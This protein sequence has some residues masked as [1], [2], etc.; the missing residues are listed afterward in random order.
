MHAREPPDTPI[1]DLGC[2]AVAW[3]G[4]FAIASSNHFLCLLDCQHVIWFFILSLLAP[5][6]RDH[7]RLRLRAEAILHT[8]LK[9]DTPS[10]RCPYSSS[11]KISAGF[12]DFLRSDPWNER[13]EVCALGWFRSRTIFDSTSTLSKN[14]IMTNPKVFFGEGLFY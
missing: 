6:A 8:N 3:Y 10:S 14:Q 11:G 7:R 2:F 5:L 1:R 4:L 12:R 9:T 13:R